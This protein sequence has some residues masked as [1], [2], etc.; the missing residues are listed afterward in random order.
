MNRTRSKRKM[1]L[2]TRKNF[3]SPNELAEL[4]A[5]IAQIEASLELIE[6]EIEKRGAEKEE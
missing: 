2:K 1:K 6:A 3:L 5:E 4:E